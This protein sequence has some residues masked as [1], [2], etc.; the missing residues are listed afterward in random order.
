LRS[1]TTDKDTTAPRICFFCNKATG[2]FHRASTLELD[3][4]VRSAATKLQ[5]WELLAKLATGD[6]HAMDAYYHKSCLT[7]LHN[8]LRSLQDSTTSSTANGESKIPAESI[9]LA[10]LVAY[11]LE[12]SET[13]TA[14]QFKL[15]DLAKLYSSR[16]EELG[17]SITSR[18]NASRLKDRILAQLP[19]L[20]AYNDGKEVKLAFPGDIGTAM[21][22]VHSTSYDAAAMHLAKA[23]QLVREDM[24]KKE[25]NF[26]GTFLSDCQK[27]AVPDSLLSQVSMILEG[28]NIGRNHTQD[29]SASNAST[30]ISQLLLFNAVKHA[31]SGASSTTRHETTKET[32]VS[33]YIALVIHAE[34]RKRTLIDKFHKLGLWISYDRVLQI[35]ANLANNV[36]NQFE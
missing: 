15:S 10:E 34:T 8:R 29:E 3:R 5:D 31:R 32:P 20:H 18:V 23:A 25:Q 22:F 30:M 6:M 36:C 2:N 19:K 13:S 35:S 33:I 16:L 26:N 28:Q 17:V 14:V 7:S 9:A 11:I 4:N 21:E 27:A 24:I 12:S 1:T